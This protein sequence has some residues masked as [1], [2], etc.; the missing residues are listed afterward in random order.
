MPHEDTNDKPQSASAAEISSRDGDF[1][2]RVHEILCRIEID[3]M[4]QEQY[5]ALVIRKLRSLNG[6]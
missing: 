3:R 1:R 5:L 4:R 6:D 2:L